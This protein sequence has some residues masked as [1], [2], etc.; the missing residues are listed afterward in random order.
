MGISKILNNKFLILSIVGT[1]AEEN[2]SNIFNRKINEINNTSYTFWLIK[3][4]R[5]KTEQI[6]QM[7]QSSLNT[8]QKIYCFFISPSQKN[9]AQPTKI[10]SL[11]QQFSND[12]INW[13]KIPKQI[14]VTGKID[15]HTTG[16]VFDKISLTKNTQIDLWQYS[17]FFDQSKPIKMSQGASTVC[18]IKKYNQGMKSRYRQ[19]LAIGRLKHPYAVFLR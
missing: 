2:L 3:S 8:S 7:A 16:L 14:K 4:F 11:A 18:A 5:A 15:N 1:H 12:N 19:I 10:V 6:Q 13:L 9:G 17:N